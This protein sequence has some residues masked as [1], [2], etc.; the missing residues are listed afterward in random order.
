MARTRKEIEKVVEENN[1]LSFSSLKEKTGF[2][3]GTLQYHIKES[4]NIEKRKSAIMK[5]GYC[6][7]CEFKNSCKDRC[8]L[9]MLQD[10][11]TREIIEKLQERK[12]L[13][14]IGEDLDLDP[15][16]V[17]YHVKKLEDHGILEDRNP[18]SK[19]AEFLSL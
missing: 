8:L 19:V 3:N 9:K 17:H 5:K 7:N 12:K 2:G 18:R 16:T 10:P 13:I 11:R 14:E 6:Q 4:E 15:S 1:A